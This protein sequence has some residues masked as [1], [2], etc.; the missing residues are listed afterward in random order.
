MVIK[1]KCISHGKVA[2]NYAM[3]KDNAEVITS[4]L[5]DEEVLGDIESV[6]AMM[7]L[8]QSMRKGNC[9][10]CFVRIEVSPAKDQMPKNN[11]EWANLARET[12]EGLGLTRN[13][14][15][16]VVHRSSGSDPDRQHL[17]IIANRVSQ[18][19]TLWDDS[20]CY[21]RAK[22]VA[23]QYDREHGHT[24]SSEMGENVR[25]RMLNDILVAFNDLPKGFAYN[26]EEDFAAIKAVIEKAGYKSEAK[27]QSTGNICGYYVFSKDGTRWPASKI[28][29][30][31]T[32][33]HIE[34]TVATLHNA[35]SINQKEHRTKSYYKNEKH[36]DYSPTRIYCVNFLACLLACAACGNSQ[37]YKKD[38]ALINAEKAQREEEIEK[39]R[40][41]GVPFTM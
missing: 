2:L 18:D 1:S 6:I 38:P 33:K 31:I 10:N 24:I 22:H 27:V 13:E 15:L 41:G 16:A 30:M 29:R 34:K 17:H 26:G 36:E 35:H 14:W 5:L 11:E 9:K 19:L 25:E 3:K 8:T 23:E 32:L 12:A 4:N 28:S 7:E 21:Y 40:S 39:M 37:G 20:N